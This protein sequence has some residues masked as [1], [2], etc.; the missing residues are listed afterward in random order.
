MGRGLCHD[1]QLIVW[2]LSWVAHALGHAPTTLLE[3]NINHPAPAQLTGSDYFL[4]SQLLFAPLEI[5]TGNAVLATNLTA[6]ATY[7]LA[8]LACERAGPA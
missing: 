4:S 3:A 5:A 1:A 6:L 2:I 7:C 8:G